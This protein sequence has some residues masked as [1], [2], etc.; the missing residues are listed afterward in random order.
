MCPPEFRQR[1]LNLAASAGAVNRK[2]YQCRQST[3]NDSPLKVTSKIA[4]LVLVSGETINITDASQDPRVGHADET[5]KGIRTRSVL[6][7]PVRDRHFHII[8]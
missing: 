4:E 1:L 6:C 7:K 2:T 5:V 8:E 3:E